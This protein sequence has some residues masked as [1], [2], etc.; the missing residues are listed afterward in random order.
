MEFCSDLLK[1]T[2]LVLRLELEYET[3]WLHYEYSVP[4]TCLFCV[5][6]TEPVT[7][8]NNIHMGPW[9]AFGTSVPNAEEKCNLGAKR[10]S[11]STSR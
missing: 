9:A 11:N 10:I 2:K 8:S 5:V 1:S 6:S 7:S 4:Y 3:F